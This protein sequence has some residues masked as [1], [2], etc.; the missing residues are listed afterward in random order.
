MAKISK[1]TINNLREFMSRGCKY[2]GT[3]EIVNDL[4]NESLREMGAK[5][6]EA[7]DVSLIDWDD[8]TIGTLD[9]FANIFWDKAV[10]S[11]LNVLATENISMK[12]LEEYENAEED[13][14]LVLMP[15]KIGIFVYVLRESWNGWNIDKKKFKYGMIDKVGKTV[16][17]TKEEA[18]KAL[19]EMSI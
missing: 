16:F 12:K 13:G 3:Q 1:N 11:F 17:L 15:C 14:R 18:E 10:E 19:E 8:D 4:M 6:I 9:D 7:D 2:S 5:V